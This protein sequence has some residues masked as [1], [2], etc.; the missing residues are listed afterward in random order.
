MALD[1]LKS[2]GSLLSECACRSPAIASFVR[3][4]RWN[5]ETL[6]STSAWSFIIAEC[7][8]AK[9]SFGEDILRYFP[10]RRGSTLIAEPS[11]GRPTSGPASN[12]PAGRFRPNKSVCNSRSM[13]AYSEPI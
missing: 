9:P 2:R 11:S 4:L 12:W 8:S 1:L 5:S 6:R 3:R 10:V 7:C 13:G